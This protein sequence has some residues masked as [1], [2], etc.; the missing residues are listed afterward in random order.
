MG[1]RNGIPPIGRKLRP[2]KITGDIVV[3]RFRN[4]WIFFNVGPSI[5]SY[6]STKGKKYRHFFYKICSQ[7]INN[8]LPSPK[9]NTGTSDAPV[10]IHNFINPF[11]FLTTILYCPGLE[12][13]ASCAPPTDS[14]T[15]KEKKVCFQKF[16]KFLGNQIETYCV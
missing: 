16:Q 15:F 14:M 7:K 4:S 12:F 8:I 2:M 9:L 6:T 11:R 3:S 10:T 1:L 5:W 13:S